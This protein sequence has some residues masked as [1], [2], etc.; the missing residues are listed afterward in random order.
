MRTS[1]E[2]QSDQA[3]VFELAAMLRTLAPQIKSACWLCF[4]RIELKQF[5]FV[6]PARDLTNGIQHVEMSPINFNV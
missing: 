2:E 1:G 5:G 4:S 6:A 3:V